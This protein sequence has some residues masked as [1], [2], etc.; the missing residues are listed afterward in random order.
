MLTVSA[1]LSHL[2]LRPLIA[3]GFLVNYQ[4]AR[5]HSLLWASCS[6]LVPAQV[7]AGR[8]FASSFLQ[9]SPRDDALALG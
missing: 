1:S 6:S 2:L 4:L 3:L 5:S 7:Q 9:T 8:R